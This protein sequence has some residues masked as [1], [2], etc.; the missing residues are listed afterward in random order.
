MRK[1]NFILEQNLGGFYISHNMVSF[2]PCILL[3]LKIEKSQSLPADQV[4]LELG[5]RF[6][7]LNNIDLILKV[8]LKK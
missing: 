7:H 5:D 6:S 8:V 2:A 3:S 4:L 1:L